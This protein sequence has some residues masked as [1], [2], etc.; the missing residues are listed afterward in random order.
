MGLFE[1]FPY[2]NF[3]ELNLDWWLNAMRQLE[4][5]IEALE[6]RIE[7]LKQEI[8]EEVDKKLAEFKE[9]L[10]QEVQEKLDALKEEL[11]AL[12]DT[13]ISEA[14]EPVIQR[15]EKLETD[16]EQLR[17]DFDGCCEEVRTKLS[18]IET[19]IDIINRRLDSIDTDISN[20]TTE[21]TT[22][23]EKISTIENRLDNDEQAIDDILSSIDSINTSI[24]S[25]N[26]TIHTIQTNINSL[27]DRVSAIET[28]LRG[29]HVDI[30]SLGDRVSTVENNVGNLTTIV[31]Q[32][33]TELSDHEDRI[34]ALEDSGGGG[35]ESAS[36]GIYVGTASNSTEL[37]AIRSAVKKSKYAGV[38]IKL[39][40][41]SLMRQDYDDI[42]NYVSNEDL[43]K[44]TS[45][46]I[47]GVYNRNGVT[48]ALD[49]RRGYSISH[50]YFEYIKILPHSNYIFVGVHFKD[51]EIEVSSSDTDIIFNNCVFD[52]CEVRITTASIT[53][54]RGVEF[55]ACQIHDTKIT[56]TSRKN[57]NRI[58]NCSISG[59]ENRYSTKSYGSIITDFFVNGV[60]AQYSV[61]DNCFCSP[62]SFVV[63]NTLRNN[64]EAQC[65]TTGTNLLLETGAVRTV[66]VFQ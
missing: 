22:I 16:L 63:K 49:F 1:H 47:V 9:Q 25:I 60:T 21:I 55:N 35:S 24:G 40:A 28:D 36:A 44:I 20:I 14:L 39:T 33:T 5:R 4:E 43:V 27:G 54:D 57:I 12:I 29:I 52:R 65:L 2:S 17:N 6:E 19:E 7:Q 50:S 13:K 3:H 38:Y 59:S 15:I 46:S 10:L 45:V 61:F 53:Y 23:N 11:T 51:C 37:I 8:L 34:Q 32:H 48:N 41:D 58:I 64:T 62:I 31:N 66:A 42:S 56:A 30:A 26:N 18:E